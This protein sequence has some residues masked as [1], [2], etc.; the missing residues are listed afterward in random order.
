VDPDAMVSRIPSGY[1]AQPENA[2]RPEGISRMS[3]EAY[4]K[5]TEAKI[6]EYQ[7]RLDGARAKAK[8]ASAD[9]RLNAEKQ[10]A[11]LEKKIDAARRKLAEV[12]SA[13]EGA[14]EGLAKRLDAGWDDLSD[15]LKKVLG[16]LK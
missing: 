11:E 4:R 2:N 7:A 8:G 13:A 3:K 10:L 1:L 6:E 9:A 12:S 5:K 16:R 14:W 15:R